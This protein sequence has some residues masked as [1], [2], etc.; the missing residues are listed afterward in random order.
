MDALKDRLAHLSPERQR[1]LEA[2]LAGS[3][4]PVRPRE[5][6][7]R[8]DGTSPTNAPPEPSAPLLSLSPV[9]RDAPEGSPESV[10]ATFQRFYDSVSDQLDATPFGDFSFFLNY[11]YQVDLGAQCAVVEL[12]E[13]CLNRNSVKLVLETIGN[14]P[15]EGRC[16]LDVGCGRGGTVETLIRFFEPTRVVGLDL[17]PAAIA[18]CRR[19]HR[20]PQLRFE[21]GDAEN[22]PFP[23]AS[24]DVVTNIESSHSYPNL[25][26]FYTEV[27]R[28]LE[29][30]GHFL[31]ADVLPVAQR[32]ECLAYFRDL[33]FAIE[34]DRDITNN[35][36]RS[37]DEIARS[38]VG[39]FSSANDPQLMANFR[40]CRGQRSTI[41]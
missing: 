35:V 41:P 18:F 10:K 21:V 5:N 7:S 28:I 11:G 36:L 32:R 38:R 27:Y 23:D 14:C 22:L 6:P 31:Y 24:L 1:L 40:R 19:A 4:N 20:H 37:C 26:T 17:S 33:G 2:L 34:Q 25:F 9:T 13:H 16:V 30:N 29:L 8:A 39:A 3:E 15:I 12:P